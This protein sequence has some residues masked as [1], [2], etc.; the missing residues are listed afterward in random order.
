M[1]RVDRIIGATLFVAAFG[2]GTWY[3]PQVLAAG[4]RPHFYQEE[5]GPAVMVACGHGYVNPQPT[6]DL[7][8][9]LAVQGDTINCSPALAA[10]AR[11]PL[12]AMQRAYRYLITTVGWTWWLQG[13]VAWSALAPLYGLFFAST[14]LLLYGIFRQGMGELVAGALAVVLAL[15]PLHVSYLAHLRDYSKA[16]FVLALVLVAARLIRAR[17]TFRHAA[18]LAAGAGVLNGVAMGYRNDLLVAI[19]AFVGLLL[20][21]LNHDLF[22]RGWRNLALAAV[23]LAGFGLALSP[24]WSIYR[25]GGGNSSQ[26]LVLL[27]LG[28][29]FNRELGLAGE[30]YEWGYGYRDELAHAMIS[31]N[32][33]RR[34]G[35]TT[36]LTLYGPEY[37]RSASDYLSQ[38]VKH[39]PADMLTRAYASA[40][41]VVELPYNRKLL[42]P[43]EYIQIYRPAQVLRLRFQRALAPVWLL[44][45]AATLFVLTVWNIRIGLFAMLLVFYL[46]AYPALQFGERHYFH[47]EFI[48]WWALGFVVSLAAGLTRAMFNRSARLWLDAVRP[49]QGWSRS[50]AQAVILWVAIAL[51]LLAPLYVLRSLQQQHLRPLFEKV[52]TAPSDAGTLRPVPQGNG[53]VRFDAPMSSDAI[54]AVLANDAVHPELFLAEFGGPS[55]ESLKLDVGFRYSAVRAENDFSRTL[56]LPLALSATPLRVAFP[57]YYHR[58][59]VEDRDLA[60]LMDYGFVGLEVPE[61]AQACLL[62]FARVTDTTD[63]PI[64]FELRLPPRWES[65]DLFQTIDGFESRVNPPQWPQE[66]Y[67]FPPDLVVGRQ[68]L[69]VPIEHLDAAAIFRRSPTLDTS[70]PQ[71]WINK[72]A[73]GVGGKGPFLYLFEMQ[74]VALEEG[75]LALVQGFIKKGGISFGLVSDGRW[76]AQVGVTR[77][78]EFTVVVRVPVTGTYSLVLANNLHGA[79]LENDVTIRRV[80]WIPKAQP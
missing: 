31:G 75:Q 73:G 47:L 35:A 79:S 57:A 5:F 71:Q 55:C 68:S 45:I 42:L 49:V 25:T 62:R 50:I 53:Y 54:Q 40:L 26:H 24:M 38:I 29:P 39:F 12:T 78:G 32:A 56:S 63:L 52:L 7:N 46:A 3:V 36:F 76:I 20:V 72:G 21:F 1:S 8:A 19:P 14:I 4:G 2:L 34:L 13:R 77:P 18:L 44:I 28:E 61:S 37:D 66:Y 51:L 11:S 59:R 23:Y 60:L 9:F 70:N 15:S 74:P 41:R 64:L 27:G 17:L 48:G 67:T 43:P 33:T 16:P 30:M 80:G 58:P 69:M 6:P 65:A 10:V 22:R